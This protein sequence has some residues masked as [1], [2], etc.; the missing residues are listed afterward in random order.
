MFGARIHFIRWKSSIYQLRSPPPSESE[1]N[2]DVCRLTSCWWESKPEPRH[3]TFLFTSW[4]YNNWPW[5]M[6]D[7]GPWLVGLY[8][9]SR[10]NEQSGLLWWVPRNTNV[11]NKMFETC[12]RQTKYD[13][14]E[15]LNHSYAF[16]SAFWKP[17]LTFIKQ[18]HLV[19][20]MISNTKY[21]NN[22]SQLSFFTYRYFGI[23]MTSAILSGTLITRCRYGE[24]RNV[25]LYSI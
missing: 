25:V 2:A 22:I 24:R 18:I 8:Q 3:R 21:Y 10:F 16:Y 15:Y 19:G 14:R 17:F 11:W 13:Y 20:K 7:G 5:S 4:P 1:F 23:S 9:Q 12:F 6:A